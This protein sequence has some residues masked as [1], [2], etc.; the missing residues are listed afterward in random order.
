[1][2]EKS[3]RSYLCNTNRLFDIVLHVGEKTPWR[4]SKH[5]AKYPLIT[6]QREMIQKK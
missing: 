3:Y 2:D 5:L 1:M 4:I 6:P